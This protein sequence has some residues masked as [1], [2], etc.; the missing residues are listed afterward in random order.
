MPKVKRGWGMHPGNP[1][2]IL[3]L[4]PRLAPGAPLRMTGTAGCGR[5]VA[6]RNGHSVSDARET[7]TGPPRL[8]R[9]RSLQPPNHQPLISSG[10]PGIRTLMSLRTPVF[11]TGAIAVLP[12][13][14]TFLHP[15]ATRGRNTPAA[16]S[17]DLSYPDRPERIRRPICGRHHPQGKPTRL[18]LSARSPVRDTGRG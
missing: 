11:K 8:R 15:T 6:S 9:A 13:L 14:H 3:R 10:G 7:Q 12:T 17:S 5:R 18:P 1:R 2:E 4:R 16:P